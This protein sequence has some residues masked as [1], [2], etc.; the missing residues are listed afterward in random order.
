MDEVVSLSPHVEKDWYFTWGFNQ[1]HD[2]CY[3]RI[4]GTQ[5]SSRAHMVKAWGDRWSFQYPTASQAGVEEFNL[6]YIETPVSAEEKN[7]FA[8]RGRCP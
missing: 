6:T 3:T 5:E 7:T 8:I 4:Y 2:N 1:G